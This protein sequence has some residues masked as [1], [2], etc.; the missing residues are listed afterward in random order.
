MEISDLLVKQVF[1]QV[2]KGQQDNLLGARDFQ[3]P[4]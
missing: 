1:P 2:F 3:K 4:H